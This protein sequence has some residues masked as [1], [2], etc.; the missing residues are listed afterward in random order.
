MGELGTMRTLERRLCIEEEGEHSEEATKSCHVRATRPL[1]G[2]ETL[3]AAPQGPAKLTT[4]GDDSPS[5]SILWS[6][7]CRS[8]CISALTRQASA[9]FLVPSEVTKSLACWGF[10]TI[11][12]RSLNHILR[13]YHH[14]T[15]YQACDREA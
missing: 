7:V 15:R 14:R 3:P 12:I 11:G 8:G 13:A 1:P 9:M 10:L 6:L 5:L 4:M 2:H